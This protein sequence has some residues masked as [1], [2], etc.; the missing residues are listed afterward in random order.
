LLVG[1]SRLEADHE[2]VLF[3]R[4][5]WTG[6]ELDQRF[7]W[8]SISAPG[9]SWP[10]AAGFEMSRNADVALACTTYAM[11]ATWRIPGAVIVWDFAPFNRNLHTPRGSLLER[12]TLPIAVRRS[13][14]LLAISQ[15]TRAE[16]AQRY[17]RA[18]PKGSV[19]YP[20]ADGLFSS[21]S[22]DDEAVLGR[23][24]L[25]R[26]FAL[27]TGTLEPRKNLPRLVEAFAGLAESTR[28]GWTLAL[29]G[30]SGWQTE[31]TFAS[32]AA[33]AGLV[34]TLGYVPDEDLATLYRQA[35]LFCYLSLYEGF[36]IPVLE[37]M[38]SGTCVLT[39]SVSSMPEA[40]G[41][42]ACY[43]DPYD[44]GD[45]R[46]ALGEL[47]VDADLRRRCAA[48]GIAQAARFDWPTTA[49]HVLDVLED[50]GA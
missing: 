49:R 26:P 35:E 32:V 46:R 24:G 45:I 50:L 36:G 19:A 27:V 33:H 7:S 15:S 16:L 18:G 48:A 41:D 22:Q 39:S 37:A 40:G 12:F 20:S 28:R 13:G 2:Y 44:V 11:T 6:A 1:L 38:Q 31:A 25:Q 23:Y 10:L 17:A 21:I 47:M 5:P 34:I 42:A 8:R 14:A 30:A 9:L 4:V 43:A 3:C 29:A